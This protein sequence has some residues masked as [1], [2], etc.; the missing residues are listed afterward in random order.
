MKNIK[1]F[2]PREGRYVDRRAEGFFESINS[3]L[4]YIRGIY[5]IWY[6]YSFQDSSNPEGYDIYREKALKQF[7]K[8]YQIPCS[9][10]Y[11]GADL[12]PNENLVFEKDA[13]IEV[14]VSKKLV[15]SFN[16]AFKEDDIICY[17]DDFFNITNV[18]DSRVLYDH[19]MRKNSVVLN[20][21]RTRMNN[22]QY[23]LLTSD[24]LELI[25]TE[26]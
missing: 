24:E 12:S 2:E 13:D 21:K 10:E 1:T 23:Q 26:V 5:I 6:P 8:A 20:G 3:E 25:H 19:P 9:V 4:L 15:A 7:S 14:F 22:S 17:G 16:M 18:S 11:R